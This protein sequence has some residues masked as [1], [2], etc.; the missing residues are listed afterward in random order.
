[1]LNNKLK[2]NDDKTEAM[3]IGSRACLSLTQAQ[4]IEVGDKCIPFCS[5]V[6]DLGVH[7][8]STMSMH[9]HISFLCR[10]SFLAL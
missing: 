2:L 10:S 7:L 1:M 9:E 8:D 6:K 4:A 3:N 5:R